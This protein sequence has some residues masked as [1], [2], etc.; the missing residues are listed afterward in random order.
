MGCDGE[1]DAGEGFQLQA[2]HRTIET[3]GM[4]EY[5]H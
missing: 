5:H 2:F 1:L 3:R 4:Q